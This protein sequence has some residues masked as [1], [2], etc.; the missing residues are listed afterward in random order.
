MKQVADIIKNY[1]PLGALE[2]TGQVVKSAYLSATDY[3]E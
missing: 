3:H 1:T 2:K